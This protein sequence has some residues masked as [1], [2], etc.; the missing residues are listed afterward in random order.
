MFP[1]R[2][3]IKKDLR[4]HAN[5]LQTLHK[6]KISSTQT[7]TK[8]NEPQQR[9]LLLS[10]AAM[11]VKFITAFLTQNFTLNVP[12]VITYFAVAPVASVPCTSPENVPF[13]KLELI[14]VIV[15]LTGW[16]LLP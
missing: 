11:W 14:S 4:H 8:E 5:Q 2:R 15:T 10:G 16:V 12:F 13:T 1:A 3:K 6:T 7:G 9:W